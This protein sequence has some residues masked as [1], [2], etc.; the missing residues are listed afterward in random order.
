MKEQKL[1]QS[2]YFDK[3]AEEYTAI[4]DEMTPV[5]VREI[6]N[7]HDFAGIPDKASVLD[8][9]CGAG[10]FSLSLL[11][12]GCQV[13]GTD[14]SQSSLS[15]FARLAEKRGRAKQ[16]SLV[17][18]DLTSPL[19]A[20]GFDAAILGAVIH[21]FEPSQKQNILRNIVNA[22]KPGGVM[23]C[24]EPNAFYPVYL[25]WYCYLQFSG[26]KPGILKAEKGMFKSTLRGL[27]SDLISAGL[28][29]VQTVY[30][31]MIPLRLEPVLKNVEK[32]NAVI[33]KA[34]LIKHLC[35]FI[36]LKAYKP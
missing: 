17:N 32:I 21:H 13:T 35:A 1:V 23:V 33:E 16:L 11:E 28:R 25:P 5:H 30:H 22:L 2:E 18:T 3:V 26:K 8:V 36:W 29:D 24:H 15:G 10:H 14:V 6:K 31:T 34:P 4:F 19:T 12:R 7:F 20:S 27:R 9:G